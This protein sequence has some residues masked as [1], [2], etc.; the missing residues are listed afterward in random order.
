MYQRRLSQS[1]KK[2]VDSQLKIWLADDI[3]RFSNSDYASPI[4]LV[5]KKNGEIKICIDFCK[6]NKK[7]NQR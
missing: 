4:V 2:E 3:I 5:K 7:N 1:E 6:L